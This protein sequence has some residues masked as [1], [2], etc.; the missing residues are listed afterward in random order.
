MDERYNVSK[1]LGIFVVKQIAG[2]QDYADGGSRQ[3]QAG[4]RAAELGL[5]GAKAEAGSHS[6]GCRVFVLILL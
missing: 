1:L 3:G 2:L 4:G 6:A 5:G